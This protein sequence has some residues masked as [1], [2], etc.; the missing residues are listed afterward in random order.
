[1][2]T[3]FCLLLVFLSLVASLCQAVP[4]AVQHNFNIYAIYPMN[5]E[6]IPNLPYFDGK[7]NIDDEVS[8]NFT[9][10]RLLLFGC[11]YEP[12]GD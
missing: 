5:N 12:G 7:L 1:M 2:F 10:K 4:A 9:D 11:C 6:C 3:L 8:Y